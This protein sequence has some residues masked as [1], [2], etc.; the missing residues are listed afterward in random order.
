MSI[1]HGVRS[2]VPNF[3]ETVT[4]PEV[5]MDIPHT[6]GVSRPVGGLFN[7]AQVREEMARMYPSLSVFTTDVR[8]PA[9]G[10]QRETDMQ[11]VEL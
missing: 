1:L 6:L 11:M 9:M 7:P 8:M 5:A 4:T 2:A 3:P 10:V